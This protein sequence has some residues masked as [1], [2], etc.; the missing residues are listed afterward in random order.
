MITHE[1][2]VTGG[3]T[4][5][6]SLRIAIDW[7]DLGRTAA[8]IVGIGTFL[9][10]I[11]PYGA[12]NALP[13]WVGWLYWTGMIGFG[14]MVGMTI[15]RYTLKRFEGQSGLV[16][17][18]VISSVT[19]LIITPVLSLVHFLLGDSSAFAEMPMLY[20]FV[21][22]ITAA[23]SA[24]GWLLHLLQS[25]G[26][27]GEVGEISPKGDET[28][29]TFMSRLP[30]PYRTAELYGISSEDHYLRVHTSAGEHLFLERL[31]T[32]IH[33]L[34]GAKGLQTHR[35]W[36]VAEIGVKET[37]SRNGRIT[38]TLK[39]GAEVPVS[40]TYARAVR[41]AGWV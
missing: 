23:M 12:T 22:V 20:V 18:L 29:R 38:L 39:S 14:T 11:N 41:E 15:T 30:L 32:A 13:I 16:I 5:E 36:W 37:K 10:I 2:R 33:Q 24:L 19:A 31:S 8:I 9:S 25:K 3:I 21:W 27:G 7:A 6:C 17:W 1:A 4:G 28:I 34:D 35:S 26:E 40:R